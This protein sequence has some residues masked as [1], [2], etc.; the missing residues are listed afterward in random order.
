MAVDG[1]KRDEVLMPLKPAAEVSA[2][3]EQVLE[4]AL[5]EAVGQN[6]GMEGI[7]ELP[8]GSAIVAEPGQEG[9]DDP[10]QEHFVN[11][12]EHV[13]DS[14]LRQHAS[15]LLELIDH[16]KKSREQH[17]KLYAE[18]LK[19]TG[20]GGKAP[21]GASFAGASEVAHPV[22]TEACVDFAAAA[23]RELLPASG[24]A[25]TRIHGNA[26]KE[27]RDRA[28][29]LSAFLNW[30]LT[31]QCPEFM[32]AS[33]QLLTQ[34]GLAGTQ[35]LK[36][37]PN[38]ALKKPEFEFVP[39]DDL[40]VPFSATSYRTAGRRTHVQ[41]LTK[42]LVESR[43]A[44]GLYRDLRITVAGS[45]EPKP[46]APA[47]ANQKIEGRNPSGFNDEEVRVVY[48]IDLLL[49][50]EGADPLAPKD[51]KAPYIIVI[52][53]LMID[54]WALYRNWEP[55]DQTYAR[56]DWAGE[57]SFI[58][59][60]GVYSLGF[61]HMIGG[62]SGAATGALRALL[63]SAHI[64]NMPSGVRL[65]GSRIT[66]QTQAPTPTEISEIEGP[67][68]I[69]DIRH[70]VMALPYPGPSAVLFQLLGFLVDAGKGVVTTAEE[71][72]ANATNTMP[73]GT[74]LALIEQGAKV[75]S[76]IH[77]RLHRSQAHVL[78]ILCRVNRLLYQTNEDLEQLQQKG[79]PSITLEDLAAASD[80]A[81][82]SDPLIFS[83]T[84]RLAQAQALKSLATNN[85]L[86]DQYAVERRVLESLKI[87]DIDEVLPKP[88]VP[89]EL[90][91]PAENLSALM[92]QPIM[93]FPEQDHLAHIETH[94]RFVMDPFLG[95]NELAAPTIVPLMLEHMKQHLGFFYVTTVHELASQALGVDVGQA[96][97]NKELQPKIDEVLAAASKVAHEHISQTLGPVGQVFQ[98]LLQM[99][100]E[101]MP[102]PPEDPAI[103]A[104]KV[105][106][107]ESQ[108]RAQEDQRRDT[109]TQAR[110]TIDAI[111]R[112]SEQQLKA[113][114]QAQDAVFRQ[115]EQQ[116]KVEKQAQDA[117]IAGAKILADVAMG[118]AQ[119]E[120]DQEARK[121]AG[122][123]RQKEM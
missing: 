105:A 38:L 73:V 5:A 33:E 18:G 99:H 30:Q 15:K 1:K 69:T 68:G 59:W 34:L 77:S 101:L 78:K 17:D 40:L 115:S 86:Y 61:S 84:Q 11:L 112:Q 102:Q 96:L 67:P 23:A 76:S 6:S 62:L 13:D 82:A 113:E 94:V 51:V 121:A 54:C 4:A 24:P 10:L 108:R 66:G 110:D 19:R 63:D 103:M 95:G 41:R 45:V 25:K 42:D 16:D 71:K 43:V 2:A 57:Y 12:A 70:L 116:L 39:V 79:A 119:L 64:A 109:R 85:S 93:A 20:L 14:V 83:E 90:N 58:P 114:K 118:T 48:E 106:I 98:Q 100:Q 75:F 87:P 8:D 123:L 44:S 21:G 7:E 56:L 122:V 91:A 52:D 72:I 50:L 55:D 88:K 9:D 80:V 104:A 49:D 26:T 31:E 46:T 60:R 92:G 32:P 35:Y 97:A 120:D 89:T 74:T 3:D 22:L 29:R 107:E 81:P 47:E 111:I 53:E 27:R 28:D 65:K 37:I 36:V 117:E